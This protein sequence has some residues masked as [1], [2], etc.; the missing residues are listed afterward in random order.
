[1][2]SLRAAARQTSPSVPDA[3]YGVYL[4]FGDI[5]RLTEAPA[6]RLNAGASPM[7]TSQTFLLVLVP[8]QWTSSSFT[9]RMHVGNVRC[10]QTGSAGFAPAA[11]AVQT[12]RSHD[13]PDALVVH[14]LLTTMQFVR[15]A[16]VAVAGLFEHD[17]FDLIE[18]LGVRFRGPCACVLHAG[19][20]ES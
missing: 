2:E 16:P 14:D 6:A 12:M 8:T 7:N 3:S 15:N 4:Y 19:A 13:A 10:G 5:H 11:P 20:V 9:V 18:Q 17:R 1:M